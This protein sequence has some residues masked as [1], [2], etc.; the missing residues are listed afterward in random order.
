MEAAKVLIV[1]SDKR[2]VELAVIKLSNAGYWVMTAAS[3]AEGL[4]KLRGTPPDLLLVNPALAAG[5]G[6]ELIREARSLPELRGL[7]VILLADPHFDEER[8]RNAAVKVE[9][10]LVKPFAP[11]TLLHRVNAQ[12]LQ[13]RLLRQLNPLTVLPG[14]V[15]LQERLRNINRDGERFDII[16]IDLKDFK[17]Y[18]KYYGF[19]QGDRVIRFLA[20]LLREESDRRRAADPELY[21]LGGD[22]F[23]VVL[24]PGAAEAFCEAVKERFDEGIPQYYL[25]EDRNR[26]GLVVS[27]RQ[28]F[29]EQWPV[30]SI[31]CGIVGNG[32]RVVQDWLEAEAIGSELLHY[33]KTIPG[34]NYL[35]DRRRS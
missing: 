1:D 4:N 27:N 14:K 23:C 30:M 22:D 28:G 18:N 34:S 25:E 2:M 17:V 8:F 13:S 7:P 15:H 26:G 16:F 29:I 35:R 3:G 24:A 6:Y 9:E 31:A 11:K 5:D 21:H 32:Q 19:E 10:M 33:V 12:I 20:D